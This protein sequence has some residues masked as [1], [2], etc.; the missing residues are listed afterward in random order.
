MSPNI[1]F[2]SPPCPDSYRESQV[3]LTN[4]AIVLPALQDFFVSLRCGCKSNKFYH[5]AKIPL[6]FFLIN[7][8][9]LDNVSTLIFDFGGVLLNLDRDNCIRSFSALGIDNTDRF[10]GNFGQQGV[11]LLFEKGLIS[12]DKF[13]AELRDMAKKEL[14]NDEIDA[15]WC[16]FLTGIPQEKIDLLLELRKK[17]RVLMLSNTNSIH[18]RFC[19]DNYFRENGR[20]MDDCFDKCYFSYEMHM[21]KPDEEI[22]E[23][24]LSDSGLKAEE[25]LFFDD[26]KLNIET[27]KRLGFNTYL[28]KAQEN[29]HTLFGI[30]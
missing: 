5:L 29:L 4:R 16:S 20:S 19:R 18:I 10:L 13:R 7:M 9:Q 11:F 15:A 21:A 27:A 24:L 14:M 22:F 3:L 1:F 28:V 25:C 8:L 23:T 17:Y 12:E 26:G 30:K 2:F 6:H